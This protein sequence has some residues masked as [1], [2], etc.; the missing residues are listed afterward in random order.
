MRF[1]TPSF[2]GNWDRT[3]IIPDFQENITYDGNGNILTYGRNGA[4]GVTAQT[5]DSLTYN[6]NY[7]G[8]GR[9][10]NNKLNYIH[11]AIDSS[12]YALDLRNQTDTN[13]YR[14]DAIGNL[15]Y[16]TQSGIT[17]N[18]GVNSITWSVYG[19]IQ[20]IY[21]PEDTISYTYNPAGERVS[22]T[23]NGLTTYYIRDAQGNVLA[24]YD[25]ADSTVNWREQHLYGSSRLGMW[26]PNV[27]L[28][29]SNAAAVWDTTGNKRYE[30]DNHLGN[31][32]V[33][34]TDKRLQ[35][36]PDDTLVFYPDVA[37]AQ[38]YYTF[39]MIMPERQFPIWPIWPI[40]REYAAKGGSDVYS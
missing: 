15:I 39:G 17:G 2:T 29:D 28:A 20:S 10:V 13:N 5:I 38:D 32:L 33:T 23:E 7:D 19:K 18:D 40:W 24:I 27:N 37:T 3:S 1:H 16:D 22:K 31:V 25:N 26:M 4:N 8:Y 9:L 34:I 14:Y 6:Y 21:K 36:M 35:A 12:G 30:L 11:D